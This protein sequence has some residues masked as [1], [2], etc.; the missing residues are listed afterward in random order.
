MTGSMR[1]RGRELARDIEA[2]AANDREELELLAAV[3]ARYDDLTSPELWDI[4]DSYSMVG[5]MSRLELLLP[6]DI[7]L[8]EGGQQ[9]DVKGRLSFE[10]E[11]AHGAHITDRLEDLEENSGYIARNYVPVI[12]NG[13]TVAMLCG[14]VELG[15]LPKDLLLEPYGGEAAI[16]I[17][18]G[19]TGDF[20]VDTWH[21]EP[22]N[23]WELGQREMASGYDHERLKQ[24]LIDGK[25]GY[26]VFVSE[27]IGEYLYFYYEPIAVN[28]WRIA[29]SVPESVV[30]TGA[31]AIRDMLNVFMIFEGACFVLYFLWMLF[32]FRKGL[33][34]KQRQLNT[35]N[36]IYDVDKLLFNAHERQENINLALEK[37]AYITSAESVGF[38]MR[39]QHGEDVTFV[40]DKKEDRKETLWNKEIIAYLEEYFKR[41]N[42]QFEANHAE[43]LRAK[44]SGVK[45]GVMK[46]LMAVPVED[47]DG[48][49]CGV[50]A[51]CNMSDSRGSAAPLKSVSFSFS[52]FCRN[53]RSYYAIKEQ[54]QTDMLLGMNNRN[55]Y[56]TD[57]PKFR[58]SYRKSLACVYIDVNGLH[59]LNNSEGHAAGDELLKE[60]AKQ[61]K[62]KFGTR[63]TYRIGGDEFLVVILDMEEDKVNRLTREIVESLEKKNIYISVGFQWRS[64]K[65][66][67]DELIKDAEKKMYAAKKDYYEMEINDRRMRR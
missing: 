1:K 64:G 59:E 29:L 33:N 6:G 49:I 46:N 48:M 25:T 36:Y 19:N 37:I 41:G 44:L 11:A 7:L 4:L 51:G 15:T 65:F 47:A 32:S 58:T 16:Y 24:G 10:Q 40:W 54:G 56:E 30:F 17:I 23:I 12:R 3:I 67:V 2:N 8:G 62:G 63:Y 34:E 53:M 38:W 60:V 14:V 66:S 61:I 43:L 52:M 55:R 31:N 35:A 9:T 18:D 42:G 20:L 21:E 22:G 26:V 57:L 39:G 50:L 27:T 13:E 5:M 45:P 28:Q